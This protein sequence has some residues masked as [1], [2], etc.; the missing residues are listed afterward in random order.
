MMRL[1]AGPC[2]NASANCWVWLISVRSHRY[3]YVVPLNWYAY[4]WI[5]ATAASEDTCVNDTSHPSRNSWVATDWL[6]PQFAP[7]TSIYACALEFSLFSGVLSTSL[8]SAITRTRSA[9]IHDICIVGGEDDSGI[10][11]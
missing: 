2:D 1:G 11:V 6:I 9:R 10:S 4:V 8:P 7:V 3:G 5:S